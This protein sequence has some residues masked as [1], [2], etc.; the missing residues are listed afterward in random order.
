MHVT[1][2]SKWVMASGLDGLYRRQL[3]LR[4]TFKCGIRHVYRVKKAGRPSLRL[5]RLQNNRFTLLANKHGG[6]GQVK[7]FRQA[8][9]L[10][11]PLENDG[12]GFHNAQTKLCFC[13]GIYH[14]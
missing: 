2:S 4:W 6:G 10:V 11:V 3:T 12:G 7:A 1:V 14:A 5:R 8:D 13:P 9:G